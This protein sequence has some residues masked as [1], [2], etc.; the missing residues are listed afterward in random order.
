MPDAGPGG[1][2]LVTAGEDFESTDIFLAKEISSFNMGAEH[3]HMQNCMGFLFH[4]IWRA[5]R[6]CNA[7]FVLLDL[8]PVINTINKNLLMHCDLFLTPCLCDQF[9]QRALARVKREFQ[10]WYEEYYG[11]GSPRSGL[12]MVSRG[13]RVRGPLAQADWPLPNMRPQYAG[14][15]I[16]G[17]MVSHTNIK[18]PVEA[19]G[20]MQVEKLRSNLAV[21]LLS[22]VI[23]H[24]NEL[25]RHLRGS[26]LAPNGGDS[27][28]FAVPAVAFPNA[29]RSQFFPQPYIA[30]CIRKGTSGWENAIEVTGKPFAFLHENELKEVQNVCKNEAAVLPLTSRTVN[31]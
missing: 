25:G 7:N 14:A 21:R 30:E 26:G 5:A 1:L 3:E 19:N 23:Y 11:P 17:Y 29:A 24:A 22:W 8:A 9:S 4:Q 20:T 10:T 15:I 27:R 12:R 2:F 6:A 31:L 18:T 16:Q 13:Y 28:D